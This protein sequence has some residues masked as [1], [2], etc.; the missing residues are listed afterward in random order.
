MAKGPKKGSKSLFDRVRDVSPE[1][2]GVIYSMTDDALRAR[3]VDIANATAEM[4]D[5]KA[6]D[7]A[8]A[9]AQKLA[10]EMAKTYSEPIKAQRLCSRLIIVTL[11]E[12]GKL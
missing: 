1:L 12:R 6:A 3:L 9:D 11:R 4:E 2:A 8:L 5:K 10:S 7:E